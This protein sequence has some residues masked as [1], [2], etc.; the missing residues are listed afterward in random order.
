MAVDNK[1][2]LFIWGEDTNN[3]RLRK[4]KLFFSFPKKIKQVVLG[5]SHGLVRLA[6]AYGGVYAWGDGTYGELGLPAEDLPIEHPTSL[7]FFNKIKVKKIAAGARHTL[8]LDNEGNI[9]AMG[10]N[11]ED[12]CAISGRR[13]N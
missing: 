4:P 7:T 13:A 8:I 6:E 5:K 3:L 2:R 11:S 9:Y 10:D 1:G 12:Q